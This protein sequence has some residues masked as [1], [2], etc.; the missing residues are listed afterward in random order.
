MEGTT[1]NNKQNQML[2]ILHTY[3]EN[4]KRFNKQVMMNV[5]DYIKMKSKHR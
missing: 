5:S 4:T 1:N 2:Q 3:I